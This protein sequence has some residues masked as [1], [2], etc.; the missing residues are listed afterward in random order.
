MIPLAFC[1]LL[2]GGVIL[3]CQ[4]FPRA[5]GSQG[6]G[7]GP[8]FYPQ[9]LAWALI[10]L[11]LASFLTHLRQ[12]A[13]APTE[14]APAEAAPEEPARY[15]LVA[16]MAALAVADILVMQYFGFFV[17]GFLLMLAMIC[18]IRPPRGLRPLLLDLAYSAGMVVLVYLVFEAFIKIQLPRG[19]FLS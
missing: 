1:L 7:Q 4:D 12:P 16:A 5:H 14:T 9:V 2:G 17:A 3:A 19:A 10:G 15:G 6:F 13:P 8:A 18:L 11:G